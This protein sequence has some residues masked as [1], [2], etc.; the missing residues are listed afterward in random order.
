MS[1]LLEDVAVLEDA[2][3]AAATVRP[4]PNRLAKLGATVQLCDT[5]GVDIAERSEPTR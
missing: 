5:T 3:D 4:L 2:G 1:H